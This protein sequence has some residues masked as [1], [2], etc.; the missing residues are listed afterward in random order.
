MS[1][2]A[3]ALMPQ[4]NYGKWC[5][6]TMEKFLH[7]LSVVTTSG[8]H[9]D[10]KIRLPFQAF[11]K[12]VNSWMPHELRRLCTKFRPSVAPLSHTPYVGFI[13]RLQKAFF[14]KAFVCPK[15]AES[16]TAVFH[17]ILRCPLSFGSGGAVVEYAVEVHVKCAMTH[18]TFRASVAFDVSIPFLSQSPYPWSSCFDS[19]IDV[20]LLLKE[21]LLRNR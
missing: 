3:K 21:D 12:W 5:V 11:A 7:D 9:N 10:I 14:Q 20:F 4:K 2:L 6:S 1:D 16:A 17:L 15:T 8:W 18:F 19:M 13:F